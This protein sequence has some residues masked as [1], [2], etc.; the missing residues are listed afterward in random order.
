MQKRGKNGQMKMS[1]GMIFSIILII[2]FIA[3]AAYAIIKFIDMQQEIQIVSFKQELQDDVEAI[4]KSQQDY[5][6]EKTYYLPDEIEA[7]CFTDN[8]YE[9]LYFESDDF[10][11]G[12]DIDYIDID[13][14]TSGGDL[15]FENVEGEVSMTLVKDYGEILVRIE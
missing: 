6:Q 12:E 5:S 14:I 11:E 7:V 4:S 10:F 8:D 2:V 13:V 9:N 1:F 15:C 3:F